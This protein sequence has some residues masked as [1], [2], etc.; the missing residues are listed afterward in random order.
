MNEYQ[1]KL[2]NNLEVIDKV[3]VGKEITE[4][5]EIL[6]NKLKVLEEEKSQLEGELKKYKDSNPEEYERMIKGIVV[7]IFKP[8]NNK[9]IK[10]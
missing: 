2:K 4:E 5:R 10:T 9:T 7:C 8:C 6:L 3:K 1:K